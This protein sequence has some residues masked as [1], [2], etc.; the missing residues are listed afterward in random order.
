M[1]KLH[2]FKTLRWRHWLLAVMV[3]GITALRFSKGCGTAYTFDIYPKIGGLLSPLSGYIPFAVGDLFIFLSIIWVF[4]YPI[5]AV[6]HKKRKVKTALCTVAEYLLW[7]YVWFYAAWGLNYSQPDIYSRM[8]MHPVKVSATAFKQFAYRYADSLNAT[9]TDMTIYDKEQM[10][11]DI[12]QYFCNMTQGDK[13][14]ALG[15]NAPFNLHPH[16]KT[17]MFS[18]LSSM[19]GVTGSMAPFFCEFTIND[20]VQGHEYP[21]TYA[22]EMSHMLGVANEGE[23]NFYSYV[24]CT[25]ARDRAVRFSGYYHIFFHVVANIRPL[26]GDA[27]YE[28][29]FKHIRPEIIDLACNDQDYWLSRRCKVID[30]T[31]NFIYNLYLRGNNVDGGLKSYHGVIG[32]I[33]AWENKKRHI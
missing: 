10:E 15:I 24:A 3:A 29:F 12:L 1:T 6:R 7:I 22:H 9:Y 19:A 14:Q 2:I 30:R 25:S 33:M 26:L 17:M 28:R 5:Y 20:D 16:A 23:A 8:D 32:I 27:E 11:H 18:G 4:A 21:A 13:T 31:Q